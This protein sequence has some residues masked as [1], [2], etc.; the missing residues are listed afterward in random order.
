[1]IRGSLQSRLQ[2]IVLMA[3]IHAFVAHIIF[4]IYLDQKTASEH[5]HADVQDVA[6]SI[7]PLL[8]N[9]LIIGDLAAVQETLDEVM[10][11]GQFRSLRI[12]RS[13]GRQA[14]ADQIG[15]VRLVAVER[16]LVLLGIDGHGAD[17]QLGTGPENT[18][19]NLA[20]VGNKNFFK[21]PFLI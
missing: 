17:D 18:D 15:L 3:A 2:I 10:G 21:H 1:M 5:S 8:K 4:Q 13:D 14:L 6:A 20:A 16:Q 9:M 19:G 7:M 11:H 12:M